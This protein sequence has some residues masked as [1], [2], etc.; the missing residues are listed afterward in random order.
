MRKNTDNPEE[1]PCVVSAIKGKFYRMA[2][3]FAVH[4]VSQEDQSLY[5]FLKFGRVNMGFCRRASE[6]YFLEE[7]WYFKRTKNWKL[8]HAMA[9]LPSAR[10]LGRRTRI[11]GL[12]AG[13]ATLASRQHGVAVMAWGDATPAA[14]GLDRWSAKVPRRLARYSLVQRWPGGWG[15]T[16]GENLALLCQRRRQHSM[17][18]SFLNA[19]FLNCDVLPTRVLK[20]LWVKT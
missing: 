16:P 11:G 6:M 15:R 2:R 18:F 13:G 9:L 20:S 1:N 5:G 14:C 12:G 4:S 7:L 8:Y 10:K 3:T 17:S 19:S